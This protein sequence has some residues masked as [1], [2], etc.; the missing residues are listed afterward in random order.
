LGKG[1]KDSSK[2]GKAPKNSTL[3]NQRDEGEGRDIPGRVLPEL[4]GAKH[5]GKKNGATE[6]RKRG[7]G[8]GK[9]KREE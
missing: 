7:S 2:S 3:S 5:I 4:P 8:L 1:E 9:E 6:K